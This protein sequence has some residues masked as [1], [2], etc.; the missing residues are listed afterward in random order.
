MIEDQPRYYSRREFGAQRSRKQVVVCS[1]A[2]TMSR[3]MAPGLCE[4]T[5]LKYG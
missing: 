5:W 2:E 1:N 4:I 3:V